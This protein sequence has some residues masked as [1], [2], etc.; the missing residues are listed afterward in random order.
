MEP[1]ID[2][3]R[4][5]W[6]ASF[7]DAFLP[8]RAA[9][10]I[11]ARVAE[12]HR[13]R[14]L[15]YCAEGELGAEVIGRLRYTASSRLDFP[16]VGDWVAL[17]SNGGALAVIHAVVPRRSLFLRKAAGDL[18]KAQIVAAN[19][20]TLFV[21]TD[22]GRDFNPRR[23]E[24]YLTLARESGVRPVIL[25][26]KAD[27]NSNVADLVHEAGTV[28]GG[29]PVLPVSAI[30]GCG[31]DPL[32]AH[33]GDGATAAFIGSSGVGKSTIINRLLGEER[34][35]TSHIREDDGRGR[36]T[37]TSRQ[38]LLLPRGG[39][40]ID[41]PGMREVQLWADEESLGSV[42]PDI[43]ETA[44]GCRFADCRHEGE[45]GC[46]VRSALDDGLIPPD[47]FESYLKLRR[48]VR[49]LERKQSVRARLEEQ[50]RWKRLHRA[51]RENMRRKYGGP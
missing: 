38:L 28:A 33:I 12:E 40:V 49:F 4:L 22:A 46:A 29:V 48:E 25:L 36:H 41:T 7:A 42:F 21:V 6:H 34:L 45:P 2:L 30:E 3:N 14:Y 8:Y 19:V 24:R 9:G 31:I 17:Q 50:A 18:T 47:R 39:I 5:G 16:A 43:E 51:G 13:E 15:V 27:L 1:G 23:L 32:H 10:F 20:D 44:A 11:P 35:K 37:T 26:N